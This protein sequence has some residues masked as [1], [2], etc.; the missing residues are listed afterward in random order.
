M[1]IH[2]YKTREKCTIFNADTEFFV[3]IDDTFTASMDF[4]Y[5]RLNNNQYSKMPMRVPKGS[6]CDLFEKYYNMVSE[7]LQKST[8]LLDG[9][10]PG[11]KVCP[12]K[13]VNGVRLMH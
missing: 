2:G 3:D 1:L 12:L 7:V 8:N 9:K 11:D 13:K 5:N 6:L 4:Y 10:K